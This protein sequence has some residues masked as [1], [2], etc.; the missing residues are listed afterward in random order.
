MS[1]IKY[2]SKCYCVNKSNT[3]FNIRNYCYYCL[4]LCCRKCSVIESR[5]EQ[6]LYER[7]ICSACLIQKNNTLNTYCCLLCDQ[8]RPLS[9]NDV[10]GIYVHETSTKHICGCCISTYTLYDKITNKY[11]NK[12]VY[13]TLTDIR[14]SYIKNIEQSASAYLISDIAKIIAEYCG[15]F[16]QISLESND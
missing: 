10:I 13:S 2:T 5:K 3:V 4:S 1:I 11:N 15:Y 14:C 16:R 7:L 6:H 9:L 12:H 8:I